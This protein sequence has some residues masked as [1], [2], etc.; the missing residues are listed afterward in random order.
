MEP[1]NEKQEPIKFII[2]LLKGADRE[3]VRRD[4]GRL[5][6]DLVLEEGELLPK[7]VFGSTSQATYERIFGAKVFYTGVWMHLRQPQ[8]PEA[9]KDRI[10]QVYPSVKLSPTN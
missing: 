5:A 4:L 6:D 10:F 3:A 2:E 7:Y 9:F 1:K 8:V